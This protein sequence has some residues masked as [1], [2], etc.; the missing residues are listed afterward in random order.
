MKHHEQ[1]DVLTF[2]IQECV[3]IAMGKIKDTVNNVEFLSEERND[4]LSELNQSLSNHIYRHV[5]EFDLNYYEIVGILET[6]KQDIVMHDLVDVG[7]IGC[8]DAMKMG[9]I[10]EMDIEFIFDDDIEDLDEF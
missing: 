2:A 5:D 1:I 10:S 3:E 4:I 7:V 6:V 9:V 8:L